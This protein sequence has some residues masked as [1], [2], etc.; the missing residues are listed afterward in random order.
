L[1]LK[2]SG[3]WTI[4]LQR[5]CNFLDKTTGKCSIHGAPVQSMICKSYDAHRCWYVNAFSTEEFSTAISFNTDMLIWFEKRYKL[6]ENNFV[7][8]IDWDE[9]CRAAY[10]YKK[11]IIDIKPPTI[12]AWTSLTLS[13]KNSRADHL[14]FLPPYNR[15]KNINHYELISFRLGFPGIQLAITDTCWAFMV[16][17]SFNRKYLN[18]IQQEYYPAIGHKDGAYSFDSMMREHSPFSEAGNQ[19]II[20]QRSD[21]ETLKNLT[22]FDAAGRV[23][24]TPSSSDI[25]NAL[26]SK[27]PF[28]AA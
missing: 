9:L 7:L 15:P 2:Q 16:Q 21:L 17:T 28:R 26:K 1:V 20:L 14:L 5:D 10:E 27:S 13:F 12:E 19:W 6:I 25:L 24:K 4:Y 11:N 22:I 18:L 3:E 8:D 23:L